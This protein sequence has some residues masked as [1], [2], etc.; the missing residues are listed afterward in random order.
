MEI[1]F[2]AVYEGKVKELYCVAKEKETVL[3][4]FS[5]VLA[6]ASLQSSISE[7]FHNN[8][9]FGHMFLLQTLLLNCTFT[10]QFVTLTFFNFSFGN[11]IFLISYLTSL[12]TIFFTLSRLQT[13]YFVF[14]DAQTIFFNIFH[15]LPPPES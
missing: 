7:D 9:G 13:I 5:A 4:L 3:K 10:L 15:P 14:L 2:A 11:D 8:V 1:F 6:F 12:Q